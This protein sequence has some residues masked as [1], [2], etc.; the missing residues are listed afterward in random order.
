M[1]AVRVAVVL[2]IGMSAVLH[3]GMAAVGAVLVGMGGVL[4]VFACHEPSIGLA[5]WPLSI[6][7]RPINR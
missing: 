4:F 5:L 3:R 7:W 1:V 2:V 6:G